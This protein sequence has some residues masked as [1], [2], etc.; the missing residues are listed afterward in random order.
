MWRSAC[1]RIVLALSAAAA[2][3]GCPYTPEGN[4]PKHIKNVRVTMFRNNTFYY[5]LEGRLTRGV[6]ARM[7]GEPRVTVVEHGEDALL[8]GEI[9]DVQKRVV[10]TDKNDRPTSV[11]LIITARVTF[12]DK[13]TGEPLVNKALIR[14]TAASSLAGI[15]DLDR[16]ETEF[17]G[18]QSAINNLAA[19][20]V[21]ETVALWPLPNAAAKPAAEKPA[22]APAPAQPAPAAPANSK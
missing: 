3:S 12:S 6:I 13:V 11:R 10:R 22:A 21:R 2:L 5:G 8:T 4:L 15:Y 19:E 20:I 16:G 14:S 1:V 18:E 9:I 17:D 7:A